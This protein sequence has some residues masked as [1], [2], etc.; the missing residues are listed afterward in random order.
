MQSIKRS[1]I[2]IL[3]VTLSSIPQV[4]AAQALEQKAQAM[5]TTQDWV[6][7]QT[8]EELANNILQVLDQDDVRKKLIANGISPEEAKTRV[9]SLNYQDLQNMNTQIEQARY[10]GDILIA[11][12][13]V[14][15]IIYLVKRI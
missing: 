7:E 9:A 12:L 1:I 4:F 5:V 11:I 8:K 13:I 15:L 6:N 14:V 2:A 10:G 3:I